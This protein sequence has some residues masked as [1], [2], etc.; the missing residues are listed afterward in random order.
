MPNATVERNRHDG[1]EQSGE[2]AVLIGAPAGTASRAARR[3]RHRASGA[4]GTLV[5]TLTTMPTAR[6]TTAPIAMAAPTLRA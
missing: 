1:Q 2:V 5:V 6:P 4:S 3:A